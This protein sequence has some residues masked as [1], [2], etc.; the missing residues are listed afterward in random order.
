MNIRRK[1]NRRKD[2]AEEREETRRTRKTWRQKE[3][4]IK[5]T[6][7][8]NRRGGRSR[9]MSL[10]KEAVEE[11]LLLASNE[12]A[13]KAKLRQ[14]LPSISPFPFH[15]AA[16]RSTVLQGVQ[17]DGAYALSLSEGHDCLKEARK[18]P[19]SYWMGWVVASSKKKLSRQSIATNPPRSPQKVVQ[20]RESYSKW[21]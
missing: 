9:R 19:R 12:E 14:L 15:K 20:V 21:P 8:R 4:R 6:Y 5:K 7:R 11:S 10:W 16:I 17:F 2:R 18:F 3:K 13:Q 1:K